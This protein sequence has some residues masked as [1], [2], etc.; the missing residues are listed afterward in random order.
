MIDQRS[1]TLFYT[2]VPVSTSLP[3]ALICL[4]ATAFWV[5]RFLMCCAS[6]STATENWNER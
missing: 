6:S 1:A 5:E 3:T 4:A 2:G